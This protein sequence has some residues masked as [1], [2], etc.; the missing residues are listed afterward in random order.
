MSVAGRP[1]AS[2]ASGKRLGGTRSV[3]SEGSGSERFAIWIWD[4]T[5]RVPP[6]WLR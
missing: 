4:A 5:E 1:V 6:E 3:A 2:R